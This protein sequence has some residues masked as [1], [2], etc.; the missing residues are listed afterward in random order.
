MELADKILFLFRSV[1]MAD[2]TWLE[3][4]DS[5]PRQERED[6]PQTINHG[7]QRGDDHPYISEDTCDKRE[8]LSILSLAITMYAFSLLQ[9]VLMDTHYHVLIRLGSQWQT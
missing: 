3:G 9:Y 4:S 8:S 1:L 2:D 6:V 5:M 7:I